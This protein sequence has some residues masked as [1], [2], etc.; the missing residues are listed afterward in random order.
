MEQD[1]ILRRVQALLNRA[2]H[3]ETP[4]HEADLARAKADEMMQKYAIEQAQLDAARP[5]EKRAKPEALK[6]NVC[7]AGSSIRDQLVDM[8][9]ALAEHCRAKVVYHPWGSAFTATLI[10]YP[11]DLRYFEMLFAIVHLHMS[12]RI[13][14]KPDS[15]LSLDENVYN[16]HEAGI[17]YRRMVHLLFPDVP[18]SDEKEVRKYGGRCKAAYRRWCKKIGEEPHAIPNPVRYQRSFA[19]GYVHKLQSRLWEMSRKEYTGSTA[20]VLRTESI[21]DLYN[22]MF[23]DVGTMK[24]NDDGKLDYAGF[25]AGDRAGGEVDLNG[26]K[27]GASKAKSIG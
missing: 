12:N 4:E 17:T 15:A 23:P 9:T 20:L 11:A 16:M 3:P 8:C 21:D 5:A 18:R 26:N 24:R 25:Y 22:K 1:A 27:T 6:V 13:E 2:E 19:I 7:P 14:P 10:G